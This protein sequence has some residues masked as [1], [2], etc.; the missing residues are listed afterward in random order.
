M[1]ED[2]VADAKLTVAAL[3]RAGH[4]VE[5]QRIDSEDAMRAAL[6]EQV[7]DVVTCDW[8]MPRFSAAAALA[9]VKE[10]GLDL[11]FI[12]VSGTIGEEL[13]VDMMRAGAHDYVLKDRLARLAPALER[14][15]RDA[16]A[17][18]QQRHAATELAATEARYRR[19]VENTNQGVW[20]IDAEGKTSFLNERMAQLLGLAANEM[21]GRTPAEFLH[22]EDRASF[23]IAREHHRGGA[24]YQH[25][26]RLL[27]PDGAMVWTLIESSPITDAEGAHVASFAMVMD[28]T[29]RKQAEASL[30][31]SEE[32][33]RSLWESS[34]ILITISNLHGEIVDVNEGF[35][36]VLG[37]SREELLSGRIRWPDL[38]PPAWTDAD[39]AALAQLAATGVAP[40]WEKEL[41]AKDGSRVPILAGAVMLEAN[42]GI[43]IAIDLSE[44]KRVDKALYE[45]MKTASL[46]TDIGFALTT[47]DTL[48]GMLQKCSDA[49]VRHLDAVFARIWT[50]EPASNQ[51]ELQASAGL[52]AQPVGQTRKPI[53]DLEIGKSYPLVINSE[54]VGVIEM[55][56]REG[57]T[58]AVR[59][60]MGAVADA[61]AVGIRR[62]RAE[63]AK[64]SLEAQLRQAQKLEAIGS[65]AGGVA[66]DFNNILSVILSY[67]EF[68]QSDLEPGHV[69]L[70]DVAEIHAAAMRAAGLTRQLLAFS[71]QQMLQ[72]RVLDLGEV[73]CDLESMLRRLLSEDIDLTITIDPEV[74]NIYA[75][76]GQIEQVLMNLVVNARDAM[77][78]GGIVT[79]ETAKVDVDAAF[80]T[81]HI[82][83]TPGPHAK[84]S[85]TDTGEGMSAEVRARI[86]EPFF[87]TKEK[88]KGTGL[89]LSTV[90]GIV[91][92]SNGAI[93]VDSTPGVGTTFEVYLPVSTETADVPE[94][95]RSTILGGSETI[96]L[97]E[98]EVPVRT[99]ARTVLTRKGYRVLE[100]QNG[101]EALLL[102]EQHASIDLLVTDVVM[103]MMSG[104]QLAERLRAIRPELRVLYM[105][106]Y[107]EDAVVRHGIFTDQLAFLQK[108]ITPD[109]MARK[110]REVLDSPRG[111]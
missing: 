7:W 106:G 98:D 46:T 36:R 12:I 28:V 16:R 33:F 111:A 23:A 110:V 96:L 56:S 65:L 51:L 39:R 100:A 95:S 9:V 69:V 13:A 76:P 18:A 26:A 14:E 60:A 85:V 59:E 92:Q 108:P 97:C 57:L 82:G 91:R 1:V 49:I 107:T 90:F 73:I 37:Y 75:D 77:G 52:H 20:V 21:I 61:I 24:S 62:N 104:R 31:V 22:A 41:V 80:A 88:G 43:T 34:I 32:R 99:L 5:H 71:R 87:T 11:P 38:T 54:L 48:S 27:R 63:Q 6:A 47:H 105:S 64:E 44:R 19:I 84:V 10:S 101:G 4:D 66:H 109:V 35:A 45:R 103:P 70:G 93:F 50:V 68:I 29:A 53:A 94:V 55:F 83:V 72:P 86:F 30:R 15:L 74:G 81:D 58:A 2:S 89:G 8:A 102:C 3:R 78:S 40:P 17:R 42:E 67:S 25:E 79:I